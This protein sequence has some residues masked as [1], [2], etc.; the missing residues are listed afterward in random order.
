MLKNKEARLNR[1]LNGGRCLDIAVDHGVCNEPSFLAGLEVS[2]EKTHNQ[3]YV[4]AGP[5]LTAG[6]GL[7]TVGGTAQC[8]A[9]NVGAP[10]GYNCTTL[11]NPNPY[12]P[13]AGTVTRNANYTDTKVHTTAVYL[14]DT[15]DFS[16]RWS[17]NL[18]VRH[19]D[20]RNVAVA[21]TGAGQTTLRNDASFW[22]YQAGLVYKPTPNS[23]KEISVDRTTFLNGLAPG[24][25]LI[26]VA[27][28][29]PGGKS[30]STPISFTR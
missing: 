15:I 8:N 29:S 9:G 12:D 2:N 4:V 22:N 10:S 7:P 11:D 23:S 20:Y 1:L 27:A 25:Y 14:F 17:L 24:N 6:A 21:T 30:R 13:W 19:D 3:G 28:V 18:G 26:T 16:D 5:G